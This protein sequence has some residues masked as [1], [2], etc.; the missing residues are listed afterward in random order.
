ME[1]Q[2]QSYKKRKRA[3]TRDTP[4]NS[5]LNHTEASLKSQVHF[6]GRTVEEI[7]RLLSG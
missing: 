6:A 7:I 4:T 1:Q 2:H 5:A 3:T